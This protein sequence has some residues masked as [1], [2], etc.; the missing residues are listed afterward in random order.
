[1]AVGVYF[2]SGSMTAD[3]YDE[4]MKLL[5]AAGCAQTPGRVV[6][7]CYG[8]SDDLATFDIWESA[9]VFEEYAKKIVPVFQ[10]FG[11]EKVPLEILPIHHLVQPS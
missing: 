2:R 6:H 9:E 10:K 1:M 11:L 4:V 7:C 3:Q 8:P 5:E